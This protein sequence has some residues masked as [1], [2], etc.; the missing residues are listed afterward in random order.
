MNDRDE[1]RLDSTYFSCSLPG[2]LCVMPKNTADQRSLERRSQFNG[3]YDI[4]L[5]IL[6]QLG[7]DSL[8]EFGQ[9]TLFP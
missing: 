1:H 9:Q 8:M 4:V 6:A 3:M 2:K 7:K 5:D